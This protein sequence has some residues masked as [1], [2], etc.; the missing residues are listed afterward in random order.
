MRKIVSQILAILLLA[1]SISAQTEEPNPFLIDEFGS[2][3]AEEM[4]AR[5]DNLTNQLSENPNT[6]AIIRIYGGN[7]NCFACHYHRGSLIIAILKN[8][9]KILSE[10]Y[11]IEHCVESKED[12]RTE[13][14]LMPKTAKLPGCQRT[15]EIPKKSSLFDTIHFISADEKLLPLEDYYI[16]VI[17]T[18][19][20]AYSRNALKAVKDNL[21]KSPEN[22]IYVIA[23]LGTNPEENYEEENGKT[24]RKLDKKSLAK[25]MLLNARNEIIKNGI[26]PFQI[27]AIDGG[28]VEGRRILEFWFV[29]KGGEIPKPKPDYFP[30]KKRNKKK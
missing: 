23:Y 3:N 2:V 30:K 5:L 1:I 18:A 19:R 27:E 13:L 6:K 21:D 29:P 17:D 14:Y 16:D 4:F 9:R 10:K 25:K 24:I 15:L 20:G 8:T 26:K 7:E 12:L 22:K 28:Y 11:L